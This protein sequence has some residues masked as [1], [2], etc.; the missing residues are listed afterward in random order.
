PLER[1]EGDGIAEPSLLRRRDG[2]S[3]YTISGATR[4]TSRKVVAAEARIVELAG[5]TDGRRISEQ[6]VSLAL[7]ESV[8]NGVTLNAGQTNLVRQMATSG[9]R[10]QLALAAAGSGKTTALRVLAA[11]WRDSGGNVIGLAPSAVA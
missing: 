2:A 7:L 5:R 3:V 11:A 6:F 1:P 4:F 10:V 9:S 8:A